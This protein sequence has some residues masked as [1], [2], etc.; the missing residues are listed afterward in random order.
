LTT[1]LHLTD[2]HIGRHRN[3]HQDNALRLLL[4]DIQAAW[5]LGPCDAIVITGDLAWSGD[6]REYARVWTDLL[7][8]LRQLV[9]F[10][11]A[12]ILVVP[13]NHDLDCDA[14]SP[15]RWDSI[16]A[17]RQSL[18]FQE[19]P[20]GIKVREPRAR[21]FHGF[22]GMTTTHGLIAPRPSA[23]VSCAHDVTGRNGDVIRFLM[24]NTAFFCD[25][26]PDLANKG[27]LPAPTA[28]LRTLGGTGVAHTFILGHHPLNWM[29]HRDQEPLKRLIRDSRATYLHGH[30]HVVEATIGSHGLLSLGFGAAYQDSP[31]APPDAMYRNSYALCAFRTDELHV[32][33][34]GWRA[35]VGGWLPDHELPAEFD[36]K[37]SLLPDGYVFRFRTAAKGGLQPTGALAAMPPRATRVWPL[38]PPSEVYCRSMLLEWLPHRGFPEP[39]QRLTFNSEEQGHFK[40]HY[41]DG[42]VHGF[43][44]ITQPGHVMSRSFVEDLNNEIDYEGYRSST[45]LTFGSIAGDARTAYLRL[46]ASKPLTIISDQELALAVTSIIPSLL[47]DAV[48]KLDGTTDAV[49]IIW[50]AGSLQVLVTDRRGDASFYVLDP[51]GQP[52]P[53]SSDVVTRLRQQRPSLGTTRYKDASAPSE[54]PGGAAAFDRNEYLAACKKEYNAVKYAALAH[55]GLRLSALTLS[56]LYIAA[57]GDAGDNDDAT[58]HAALDDLIDGLGLDPEIGRQLHAHAR[59]VL[60]LGPSAETGLA[61][62]L[63]Q[64]HSNVIVVGDPGSGKSCFSK[65]EVLAYCDPPTGVDW[66]ERH[67]PI[68][69]P[70]ID[71]ARC[72]M[73]PGAEA[74]SL[75][76]VCSR[77]LARQG[78]AISVSQLGELVDAGLAAFFF[79]GLD[80]VVSL[81]E[82]AR[83]VRMIGSLMESAATRGCRFVLTSR[84]AAVRVVDIPK[85]LRYIHLKGLTTP[86]MRELAERL[87]AAQ[88]IEEALAATRRPLRE[89]E[90]VVV[91]KLLQDC[92]EVPG[93][94]KLARNPLLFTLLVLIYWNSGPPAARRH[95]IYQQAV[96][97]LVSVRSRQAGQRPFSEAD[98]RT[99]LGA[100]ALHV[101]EDR[102]GLLPTIAESIGVLQAAMEA[103]RG[104]PVDE[105]EVR[106]F[107]QEVAEAT[108]LLV[109]HGSRD[110]GDDGHVSFMHH[111][112]MEYYAA[113]G[114]LD[115]DRGYSGAVRRATVPRWREVITLFAGVLGDQ[116][117]IT[118]FVRDILSDAGPSEAFTHRML[119]F[120]FDC[121]LESD[122]P[123]EA[124]VVMLVERV[125]GAFPAELVRDVTLLRRLSGRVAQ[126]YARTASPVIEQAIQVALQSRTHLRQVGIEC[127]STISSQGDISDGLM[128]A[129]VACCNGADSEDL[130][131]ICRA[132]GRAP[133]LRVP[134][135]VLALRAAFKGTQRQ[136]M[137]AV[138][139]VEA[140]PSLARDVWD[141]V[142]EAAASGEAQLSLAAANAMMEAG[143]AFDPAD[144]GDRSRIVPALRAIHD[145]GTVRTIASLG[146]VV[147]T[148]V[149]AE[150]LSDVEDDTRHVGILLLP[151]VPDAEFVYM[152]SMA[153]VSDDPRER[154]VNLAL[155]AVRL[156]KGAQDLMRVRDEGVIL[157][158]LG[159]ARRTTRIAALRLVEE[160]AYQSCLEAVLERAKASEKRE[161]RAAVAA[162]AS[163]GSDARVHRFLLQELG[164]LLRDGNWTADVRADYHALCMTVASVDAVA[165]TDYAALERQLRGAIDD[166]RLPSVMRSASLHAYAALARLSGP[167]LQR[168][169]TW[170][171]SPP[172]VA[173]ARRVGAKL[174]IPDASLKR[175][176]EVDV[177][178]AACTYLRRVRADID[179]IRA[180]HAVIAQFESAVVN[181]VPAR[182]VDRSIGPALREMLEELA[183][184]GA[185][186]REFSS[187]MRAE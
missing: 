92:V 181:L 55:T 1:W 23:A 84:P 58:L 102:E 183:G 134:S 119:E 107:L 47:R 32:A 91:D 9:E 53:E 52:A 128:A 127:L 64:R 62:K 177:A 3:T 175:N 14:S 29:L 150:L 138:R 129:F 63:Y 74:I 123:P 155:G 173:D 139:A 65:Y 22:E 93:I 161:Y 142:V 170:L 156:S 144:R 8:P 88:G 72:I 186:Y 166:Y 99:R 38:S 115:R 78:L 71:A 118:A 180:V 26:E 73:E 141:S 122:V 36:E 167:N 154:D 89:A 151:W 24:T 111:S 18:F 164:R 46:K 68:Y 103:Q 137:A 44:V 31:D 172:I 149:V 56:E 110:A 140:A 120:A 54:R 133:K 163:Y 5:C 187:R 114:L 153:I 86:E 179:A 174:G 152:R 76:D 66:Y 15:I 27:I 67:T 40:Y 98:L 10:A 135:A 165:E 116:A 42:T 13:G 143:F 79:D 184:I 39:A 126:L 131:A 34:R 117:D 35:S 70:L 185:A 162:L 169:L 182:G 97:S 12:E 158:H 136:R 75:L 132:I 59:R 157:R 51:S 96:Q 43:R 77:T 19:T 94:A 145:H 146:I 121:A 4:A 11:A 49:E 160:L 147:A 48:R 33:I 7:L 57:S 90:R 83:L 60:G 69:V 61:R 104:G 17:K 178:V 171:R 176:L 2:L 109:L 21:S 45:V 125:L 82:R 108:G 100:L 95:R 30:S 28:S 6:P 148:D 80:E 106:A 168:W 16:G 101:F 50:H 81:T 85:S 130:A 87:V 20:E 159:G 25:R 105:S 37:S 113:I 41:D 124:T 112:F